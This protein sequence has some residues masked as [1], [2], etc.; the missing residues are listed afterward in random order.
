V[1]RGVVLTPFG[2]EHLDATYSWLED[3]HL[4]RQIDSIGEPDREA[5]NGYWSKRLADPER[6]SY[7]IISDSEYIG[8]CGLNVDANRR[9]AELWIYLGRRRS[10]G[11][12][13]AAVE[14]LLLLA[15]DVLALARVFVRV[16]A[17]NEAAL[18]FWRSMGFV[19]EGRLR[20][21]TWAG[22]LPV[23]AYVLS[24]LEA[25]RR[26]GESA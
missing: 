24:L 20:A 26:Q 22:E 8:N 3:E 13:R 19:E 23:D 14:Q 12:G 5:H 7:A 10:E 6:P 9:K 17:T 1:G 21:D 25:D 15:F 11:A 16:L 4:R 2:I 18:R